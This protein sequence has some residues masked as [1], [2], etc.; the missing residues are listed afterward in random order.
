MDEAK[1]ANL[2]RLLLL[3]WAVT[4]KITSAWDPLLGMAHGEGGHGEQPE[5][6]C[7]QGMTPTSFRTRLLYSA[8]TD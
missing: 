8:H 5:A 3:G 1:R 4:K 6:A 2:K 7:I